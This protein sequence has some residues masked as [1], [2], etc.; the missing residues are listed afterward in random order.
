MGE[1]ST[2]DFHSRRAYRSN[3][4]TV[5]CVLVEALLAAI[6]LVPLGLGNFVVVIV[7]AG[8]YVAGFI[9]GFAAF[10]AWTLFSDRAL[11]PSFVVPQ[12]KPPFSWLSRSVLIG[13][14]LMSYILLLEA[15]LSGF[16]GLP[17]PW[18]YM[19]LVLSLYGV[20]GLLKGFV[21][22]LILL[23]RPSKHER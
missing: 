2:K 13:M 11:A 17:S 16:L 23:L 8:I 14:I 9:V 22:F 7:P 3:R 18:R 21:A 12:T 5:I 6:L 1:R 15:G 20:A 19:P 4:L 10:V